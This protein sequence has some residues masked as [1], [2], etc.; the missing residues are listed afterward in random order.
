LSST[1]CSVSS[2]SA[3]CSAYPA[4]CPALS[5]RCPVLSARCSAIPC[6]MHD[7]NLN[8][9]LEGRPKPPALAR[10]QLRASNNSAAAIIYDLQSKHRIAKITHDR[11]GPCNKCR[12]FAWCISPRCTSSKIHLSWVS[13]LINLMVLWCWN[14]VE[15]NKS[16][17]FP[18]FGNKNSE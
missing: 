11:Q 10:A 14:M 12:L 8:W 16:L 3:R 4:R 9:S 2:L 17:N 18:K 13:L 1:I 5:A 7:F 6:E 15:M